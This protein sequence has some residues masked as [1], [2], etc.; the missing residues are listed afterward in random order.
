MSYRGF[1]FLATAALSYGILHVV[2]KSAVSRGVDPAAYTVMRIVIA[3][4]V[5]AAV[6]MLKGDDRIRSVF[7]KDNIKD[8]FIIG[9]FGSGIGLFFQ[10][11]G[12]SLSSVTNVS[13]LL[14]LVAPMTSFLA[15]LILKEPISKRFILSSAFM[16][17]GVCSIHLRNTYAPFNRGDLLV[18]F[19]MVGFAY[20][21]I[22][23]RKTMKSMSVT[24]VTFGR[25]VFGSLSLGILMP[26]LGAS[27][28]S[29][30]NAPVLVVLGGCLFGV[31]MAAYYKGIEIEGASVAATFLLFSPAVAVLSAHLVLGEPITGPIMVGI[32]LVIVG[33]FLL[34]GIRPDNAA[35]VIANV[36]RK[37]E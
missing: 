6:V 21:N 22:H 35:C 18:T 25:L 31:R 27:L 24:L 30:L 32:G 4:A 8:L 10:I 9:V 28:P 23:A 33:G 3:M 2:D 12:L 37:G 20:S 7:R 1:F 26:F 34:T 13:L 19:A 14:T 5:L 16:V 11:K 17:A 36:D 29:L 15:F